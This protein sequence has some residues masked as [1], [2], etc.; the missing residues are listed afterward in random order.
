MVQITGKTCSFREARGKRP[1]HIFAL[2]DLGQDHLLPVSLPGHE[3]PGSRGIESREDGRLIRVR[4]AVTAPRLRRVAIGISVPAGH[5]LGE[6]DFRLRLIFDDKSARILHPPIQG[7]AQA[8]YALLASLGLTTHGWSVGRFDP[9]EL[10][11][12]KQALSA[13]HPVPDWWVRLTG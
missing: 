1:A 7:G 6:D 2:C 12:D 8:R 5:N 11:A 10:F 4:L 13:A 3:S 9:P